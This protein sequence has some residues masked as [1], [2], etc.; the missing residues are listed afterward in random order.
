[1]EC[2]ECLGTGRVLSTDAE[3]YIKQIDDWPC[4]KCHGTGIAEGAKNTE[5]Q[6][7][8]DNGGMCTR[9]EMFDCH[10]IV[11]TGG[12]CMN[13]VPCPPLQVN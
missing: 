9:P 5:Q 12:R 11:G 3:F 13:V 6:V 8:P 4:P 2:P 1:M 7:Q 10:A